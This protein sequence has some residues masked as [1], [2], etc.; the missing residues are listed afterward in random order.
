MTRQRA[1]W[2]DME[3][4]PAALSAIEREWP[5]LDAE[6]AVVDAQVALLSAEGG[7]SALDWRRLRRAE[8]RVLRETTALAAR[9]KRGRRPGRVAVAS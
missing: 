1:L 9:P 8:Q 7:G 4:T 2:D 6:L 3:P 5:L